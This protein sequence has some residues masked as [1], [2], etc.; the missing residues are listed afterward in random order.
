MQQ[1][2]KGLVKKSVIYI[3]GVLF[4]FINLQYLQ[5]KPNYKEEHFTGRPTCIFLA[6]FK[7]AKSEY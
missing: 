7:I 6:L 5:S 3:M 4:I 1:H 2:G